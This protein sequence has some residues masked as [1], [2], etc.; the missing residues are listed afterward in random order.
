MLAYPSTVIYLPRSYAFL[1]IIT[2]REMSEND[3]TLTSAL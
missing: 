2:Y 1:Y 3:I